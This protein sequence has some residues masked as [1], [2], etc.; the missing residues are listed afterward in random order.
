MLYEVITYP[1]DDALTQEG[2]S[3]D[4]LVQFSALDVGSHTLKLFA[5]STAQP[6]PDA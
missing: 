3:L 5:T 2:V 1:L 6:E 4:S